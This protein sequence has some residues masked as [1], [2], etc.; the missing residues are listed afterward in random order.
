MKKFLSNAVIPA[1]A[2]LAI[3]G[4]VVLRLIFTP[5]VIETGSM[6]PTLPVGTIAFI[7]QSNSFEPGDIITFQQSD[8]PRPVTHTFIGY[9]D[10]GSLN[11]KGDANKVPD[12]HN[13]PLLASDVIGEVRFDL[14]FLAG[15]YWTSIK[16]TLS[17]AVIILM[18][19]SFIALYLRDRKEL[20]KE[21]VRE[22]T[23]IST[24]V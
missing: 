15:A 2:V 20:Q 19:A 14:P 10:D 5:V 18:V 8:M 12:I 7:Q 16:G 9:A 17:L 13:T 11:T 23:L 1:F 21:K 3:F 22:E 6:T 24:P 4:I